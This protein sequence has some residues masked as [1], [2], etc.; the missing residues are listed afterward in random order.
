[1]SWKS[2]L[3]VLHKQAYL[4]ILFPGDIYIYFVTSA[5]SVWALLLCGF[6]KNALYLI[7]LFPFSLT[8]FCFFAI[9]QELF[10]ANLE[11]PNIFYQLTQNEKGTSIRILGEVNISILILFRFVFPVIYHINCLNYFPSSLTL[12]IVWYFTRHNV[13]SRLFMHFAQHCLRV[14]PRLW[15]STDLGSSSVCNTQCIR[16][17][18]REIIIPFEVPCMFLDLLGSC[19]IIDQLTVAQIRD[20]SLVL[21]MKVVG[22]LFYINWYMNVS[23]W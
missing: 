10:R 22:M 19:R 6:P 8:W 2:D 14:L 5:N 17:R 9:A 21:Y 18:Y 20:T 16:H 4:I 23:A 11:Y 3:Y 7:S 12:L 15:Y 13:D 1:M